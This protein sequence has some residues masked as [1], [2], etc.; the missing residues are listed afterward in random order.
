[1]K[2]LKTLVFA[3]GA[4][5]LPLS[6]G[7]VAEPS[8]DAQ[9]TE[10]RAILAKGLREVYVHELKLT[11]AE[12]KAFWPAYDAY[13]AGMK[14]H[15]D[16][17]LALIKRYAAAY[18]AGPV[19]DATAKSLLSDAMALDKAEA[20]LRDDVMSKAMKALPATKAAVFYQIDNKVR[21]TFKFDL[22][23]QIPLVE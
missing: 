9:I 15:N 5:A 20:K 7:A 23:A 16:K 21:A 11:D 8:I 13:A 4:L 3:L 10:F 2:T 6:A 18:N 12:G 1:M 19:D 17:V 14:A 22:A